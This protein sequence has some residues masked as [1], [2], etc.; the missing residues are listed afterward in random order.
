MLFPGGT[1]QDTGWP[2]A[3]NGAD[4][5]LAGR[6]WRRAM[7]EFSGISGVKGR[8]F[9][10]PSVD[11][12]LPLP[13]KGVYPSY[14]QVSVPSPIRSHRP[15]KDTTSSHSR[16]GRM[17]Q[18]GCLPD[19]VLRHSYQPFAGIRQRRRAKAER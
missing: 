3:R 7:T 16:S 5:V 11:K 18:K 10:P 4:M 12:P 15:E 17:M 8:S 13:E 9:P 14:T 1:R 2:P 19:S 6:L